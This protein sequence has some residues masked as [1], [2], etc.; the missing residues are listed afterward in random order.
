MSS[1][2][3]DRIAAYEQVVEDVSKN[4]ETISD[5]AVQ[6]IKELIQDL[7]RT[8]DAVFHVNCLQLIADLACSK[9]SLVV[10]DNEQVPQKL[11][12]IL[13]QDDP[14]V[15]PHALKY[16]YRVS[17]AFLETKY[18]PVLDKICEYCQSSN[19]QLNDYAIDFIAALGR[20]GYAA[21]KV[22]DNHPSFKEKCLSRLG[23]I[24][25][26]DGTLKG[27][28]LV[29][30]TDLIE[31]H[32]EDPQEEAKSLSDTFYHRVIEGERKMTDK[33]LG[34]CRYPFTEIR[35]NALNALTAVANM[36][37][38]QRELASNPDFIKWIIDRSTEKNKESKE[39]KFEILKTIV[40]SRDASKIFGGE[41]F[42]KMRT[43]FKNGPFY[44]GV[45]EE[46]LMEDQ[47]VT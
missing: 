1:N 43:D 12:K 41:N 36:E 18:K 47:N 45:A 24:I 20:G 13:N 31:V 4:K 19:I 40:K 44:V 35:V 10:L 22:L 34:L 8:D 6:K 16:F 27:R 17:P 11:I 28:A 33:L 38:G 30:L 42:M 5:E 46:M 29:C 15:V 39:A 3:L 7:D 37:W 25:C 23:S 9:Q 14:L 32:E 2:L 26:A 21:K